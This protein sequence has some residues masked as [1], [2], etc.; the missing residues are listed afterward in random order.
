M[1]INILLRSTL[2]AK[3]AFGAL[4]DPTRQDL[5]AAVNEIVLAQSTLNRL[6]R[7][8]LSSTDGRKLLR[9]QPRITSKTLSK[10]TQSNVHKNT[11]GFQYALFMLEEEL[12]ADSRTPVKHIV[13]HPELGYVMQRY[14][15]VHDI[16]HVLLGIPTTFAGEVVVKWFEW[17]H[18]G[19]EGAAMAALTGPIRTLSGTKFQDPPSAGAYARHPD[20]MSIKEQK[21]DSEWMWNE[22]IPWALQSGQLK[23]SLLCVP[24]EQEDWLSKDLHQVRQELGI[25][26]CK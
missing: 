5:V 21:A 22:G 13:G 15:D 19:L 2:A 8:M 26:P 16:L 9:N 14:R 1:S 4:R 3:S 18:Y 12:S 7:L 10:Y 20:S 24:F 17:M 23:Q 6:H 25:T 11:L